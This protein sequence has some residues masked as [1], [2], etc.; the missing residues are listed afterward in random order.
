MRRLVTS[1]LIRFYTISH[2][3]FQFRLK[4]LFSLMELSKFKDGRETT[5]ETQGGERVKTAGLE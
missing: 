5:S 3:G 4:L 1:R 2:L